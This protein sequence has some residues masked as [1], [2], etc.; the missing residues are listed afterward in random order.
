MVFQTSQSAR[1]CLVRWMLGWTGV[2]FCVSVG[3]E[4][5]GGREEERK[6]GKREGEERMGE[7][8]ESGLQG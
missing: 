6:G 5:S 7:K 4:L 1:K 8:E 3:N 2:W